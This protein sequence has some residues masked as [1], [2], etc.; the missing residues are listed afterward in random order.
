[1][2]IT[3]IKKGAAIATLVAVTFY[4]G[5]ALAG[6]KGCVTCDVRCSSDGHCTISNCKDSPCS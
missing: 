2:L 5:L 4:A 1:M 3:Q 6:P